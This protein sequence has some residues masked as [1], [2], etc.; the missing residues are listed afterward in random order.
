MSAPSTTPLKVDIWS[1]V[2]CVWCHIGKRKFETGRER[3]TTRSGIPVEVEYHSYQLDQNPPV[4]YGGRYAEYLTDVMNL[5]EQHVRD[6]FTMLDQ[7]GEGLGLTF[8]W[9]RLQP[10]L[11]LLA[12]QA[13]HFAKTHGKQSEMNDRLLAAYFEHGRDVGNL[14]E[15]VDL[16]AEIGLDP[17]TIRHALTTE[18]YL[19]AVH[20]DIARAGQLGINSVPFFVID[21]KYGVSGAQSPGIFERALEQAAGDRP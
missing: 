21:E 8:D 9:D 6:R 15:L 10:A 16:A 7:I 18:E 14:D 12:H 3:F 13:I 1:D 4:E 2:T 17:D 20:A 5:T 11:T 19:P